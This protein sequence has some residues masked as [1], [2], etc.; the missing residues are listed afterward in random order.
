MGESGDSEET[1]TSVSDQEIPEASLEYPPIPAEDMSPAVV[2]ESPEILDPEAGASLQAIDASEQDQPL[3]LDGEVLGEAIETLP[4]D[5]GA[6]GV[7][8]A[9]A[10]GVEHGGSSTY[11]IE[12]YQEFAKPER[13][14]FESLLMRILTAIIGLNA[15]EIGP[16]VRSYTRIYPIEFQNYLADKIQ[17]G[18]LSPS[19]DEINERFPKIF[20]TEDAEAPQSLPEETVE[21]A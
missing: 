7:E 14:H 9:S 20:E 4:G 15:V 21:G 5:G 3:V 1:I 11:G 17:G 16:V 13:K 19:F 18:D 12:M 8:G 6:G 2:L 10:L